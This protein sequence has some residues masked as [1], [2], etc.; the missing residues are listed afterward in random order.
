MDKRIVINYLMGTFLSTYILWGLIIV[1]CQIGYFQFGSPISMILFTIGGNAPPIVA[2]VVLKKARIITGIKQFAKEV[3]AIKQKPQ[4]Y[5]VMI[6]FLIIYFGIPALMQG[7]SK[8]SEL[9]VSFFSIPIIIF[10]GGLEEL[11]WRYILQPSLEKQIPF[12]IAT[13]L[14]ACIWAVWHLPLFFIKGTVN[15][16]LSFGLFTIMVF[17][18]SFALATIY[19]KSKSIW[20]CILFHSMVNALSSSWIIKDSIIIK[21]CSTVLIIVFSFVIITYHKKKK[22]N[23]IENEYNLH[24]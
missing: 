10:Y 24:S 8:G 2:Y 22:G 7:V 17:G 19:Y 18:M 1:A 11:G 5:G 12:G 14:T 15:S 3:F 4:Y 20:L 6:I 16:N 23:Y 9:Y 21:T 13:S